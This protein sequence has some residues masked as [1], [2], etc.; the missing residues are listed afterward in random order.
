VWSLAGDSERIRM[1]TPLERDVQGLEDGTRG[2]DSHP[3]T[4]RS[5][6]RVSRIGEPWFRR[7]KPAQP[8]RSDDRGVLSARPREEDAE[9][10]IRVIER[11]ETGL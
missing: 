6:V 1:A 4:E 10:A 7:R 9:A 2:S 3:R 5:D 8:Q 11:D